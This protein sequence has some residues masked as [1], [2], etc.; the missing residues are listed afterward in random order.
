MSGASR[1]QRVRQIW[2]PSLGVW[3]AAPATTGSEGRRPS[4]EW[5]AAA[6]M[7]RSPGASQHQQSSSGGEVAAGAEAAAQPAPA[8][9]NMAA[10]AG[11]APGGGRGGRYTG[12]KLQEQ[13]SDREA[14]DDEIKEVE[15]PPHCPICE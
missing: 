7:K 5:P 2:L 13:L 9:A 1:Q 14:S 11:P 6:L 8:G 10:A 3:A 4:P 12:F 15:P